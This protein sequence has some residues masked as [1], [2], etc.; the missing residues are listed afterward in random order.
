M[1]RLTLLAKRIQ[2]LNDHLMLFFTG[3]H[4]TASDIAQSYVEKIEDNE[5]YLRSFNN[6]VQEGIAILAQGQDITRFGRLLHEAW[7]IKRGLSAK[8]T[9]SHIDDIYARAIKAGA[10]G[11][12]LIGAGGG[13]FMLLFVHPEKRQKIRETLKDLV[14]VPFQFDTSG[15]QI[16][17]FDP[18]EDFLS[19]QCN[20]SACG[21][22]K[23]QDASAVLQTGKRV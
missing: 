6:M 20:R 13:G 7:Q 21:D 11:G 4:R 15:S 3:I 18:E 14:Y 8:V 17:F 23:V 22:A 9:N 10:I 1:Q 16:I 2:E 12:K 5:S 19:E